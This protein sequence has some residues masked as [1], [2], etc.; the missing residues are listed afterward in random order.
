DVPTLESLLAESADPHGETHPSPTT[1][2]MPVESIDY[3]RVLPHV[4]E[5]HPSVGVRES[6]DPVHGR[7]LVADMFAALFAAEQGETVTPGP[8]F[9]VPLPDTPVAV[10]ESLVD[11]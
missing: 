6:V 11:E 9:H 10:T 5:P 7:N 1:A 2:A 3:T 4:T 8:P